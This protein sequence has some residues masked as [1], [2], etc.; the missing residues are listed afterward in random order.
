MASRIEWTK[1]IVPNGGIDETK[2]STQI[3]DNKWTEAS[4]V[5]PL[6]DGCRTRQGT[7][8]SNSI[9]LQ[10]I[11]ISHEGGTDDRE[12]VDATSEYIAQQFTVGASNITVSRVGVRLGKITDTTGSPTGNVECAIYTDN[13]PG[14]LAEVT[15]LTFAL[16]ST[17]DSSTV[18]SEYKW[19]YFTVTTGVALTATTV[20][21]LVIRHTG[22]AAAG[23]DNIDIQEVTTPSGYA[24]GQV[25]FDD[26]GTAGTW[27]GVAAADLNFRIYSGSGAITGIHDY[28]LSDGSTQR[29]LVFHDGEVYKNVA[30]TMTAVSTRERQAYTVDA[31]EFPSFAVGQ[32]RCH[33]AH[34]TDT[35]QMFYVKSGTEYWENQGIAP[36]TAVPTPTAV[37]GGDLDQS[38]TYEIDYY[39]W[40]DDIGQPSNRKYQGVTAVSQAIGAGADRSIQLTG[41]PTDVAREGDR[42]THLRFELRRSVGGTVDSVFHYSGQ[43]VALAGF[44]GTYTITTDDIS[45]EAEYKHTIPPDHSINLTAN[46]RQFIAGDASFPYR[47]WYSLITGTTAYYE[48]IPTTNFRDFGKGDGDYITCLKFIAPSS[49]VVGMKNSVWVL[50]GRRPGISDPIQI[51]KGIGIAGQNSAVV[52]GRTLLFVSDGDESKGMFAWSGG[53]QPQP[54]MG[55]DDTFK[56]L[57]Q[58][59]IKYASCAHY[60]PD[61]VRFQWWT[62]LSGS[63]QTDPDTV[64]MY[65]YSLNAWAVYSLD[66]NVIG[67]VDVSSVGTLFLGGLDG[68]ERTGDTGTADDSTT[69]VSSFKGKA[70]D[71]GAAGM[72]K[73]MRWLDYVAASQEGYGVAAL[74]GLVGLR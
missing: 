60:A 47:L 25:Y 24:G 14:P 19:Y 32:D 53:A 37:A 64:L 70:F 36:P 65:D 45:I 66:A 54:I 26:E 28:W 42:A 74:Y 52:I 33:I 50:D 67:Q 29:H 20:Y 63:A 46:N 56:G 9:A 73:K 35:P 40:N 15:G 72:I 13:A 6:P 27:T 23:S 51:A 38:H 7:S 58:A 31:D 21:H 69:V 16:F 12:F 61:Q 43:S 4:N 2:S 71:F 34:G 48:S 17:L 8:K 3:D 44:S 59:R 68:F 10:S 41:L 1:E 11:N 57:N 49:V 30:G 5:E 62:L 22:A 55:V 39:Y 18:T